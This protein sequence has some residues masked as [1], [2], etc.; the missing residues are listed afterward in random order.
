MAR[1][2][3]MDSIMGMQTASKN[4]VPLG[5]GLLSE[6]SK[7]EAVNLQHTVYIEFD[8]IIPNPKNEMSL[9]ENEI[10]DL[11]NNIHL[12]GNILE[13]PMVVRQLDDGRYML[14]AGHKRREA[15]QLLIDKG[16][17]RSDNL[18]EAKIKNLDD[19]KLPLD[20]ELKE[21]FLIRSAN[22]YR[23]M[24]DS[25]RWVETRDWKRIF[26]ELRKQGKET[27]VIPM[28]DGTE[29]EIALKGKKTRELVAEVTGISPA[30]VGQ[31]D[32]VDNRGSEKLQQALLKNEVPVGVAV[33]I[34]SSDKD[35][36][37]QI[38]E[39]IE[40]SK[41]ANNDNSAISTKDVEAAKQNL[42]GKIEDEPDETLSYDA[43]MDD[44]RQMSDALQGGN[45]VLSAAQ[46]KKYKSHIKALSKLI[47]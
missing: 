46:Y 31:Y 18:V 43:F 4:N 39:H 36:Q 33:D 24:K 30:L 20:D 37:D 2:F 35:T 25:D 45:L 17:Y 16:L 23:V 44:I 13:Q 29:S 26:T 42:K 19:L 14:I 15:I 27:A 34:A 47:R 10:K 40:K 28:E 21:L 32:K 6:T 9:D 1:K 22:K 38:L 7:K 8:K 3:N 5:E 12:N 11:A 41:K